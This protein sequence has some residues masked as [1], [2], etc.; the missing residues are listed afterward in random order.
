[1]LHTSP[2]SCF[3]P[4]RHLGDPWWDLEALTSHARVCSC[5]ESCTDS[6]FR[7][8]GRSTVARV[9]RVRDVF[10]RALISIRQGS[11]LLLDRVCGI[12]RPMVMDGPRG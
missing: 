5:S 1:M 12:I 8:R 9:R 4:C 11:A 2:K 6:L 10:L 3:K 7:A